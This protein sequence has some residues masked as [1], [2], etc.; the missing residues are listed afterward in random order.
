MPK[1]YLLGG[2]NVSHRS[3]REINLAAFEDAAP[4]P[5]VLV[6]TWARPSF[7]S[8]FD[9]R[10]LFTSYMRSLGAKEVEFVEFGEEENLEQRL[11]DADLVY[12]TGGQASVLVERAEK[13]GLDKLLGGFCGVIVGRS[14][15]ALA[16][17]RRCVTTIREKKRVRV[18]EGLGLVDVTLKAH[19]TS[20][21][22][23]SLEHFSQKEPI[24]ALPKDSALVCNGRELTAIGQVYLF[25]D[26]Q[27][28]SFT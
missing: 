12:L 23:K 18:V 5:R 25:Q 27:R 19:Y 26:G 9:K 20:K 21:K 11:L 6:F 13:A 15:G 10:R 3:A 22:D 14:A 2:E 28:R 4:H 17:C 7:D 16:L 24:F 1:I 8:R